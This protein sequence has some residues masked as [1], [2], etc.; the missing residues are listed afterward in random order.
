[1]RILLTGKNG[2]VGAELAGFL[3]R[4]GDVVGFD[5][6]ELNLSNP[7]QIRRAIREVQPNV[8]VNAAAYTAVDR[9]ETDEPQARIINVDAPALMA[10][11]AKRIGAVL[12]HYSTDYVFDGSRDRPYD[13]TDQPNPINVYGQTKFAGEEAIRAVGVPHLILRTAW[14]YGTRGR[15]FLLTILRLATEGEEL[16]IVRDQF[17]APTWSREIAKGTV[18]VLEQL[19]QY[20]QERGSPWGGTYHMTAAGKTTWFGFAEAI[21]ERSLRTSQ[22][23]AWFAAATGGHPLA[24]RRLTPIATEQY[25]TPARRPVYSVL[26]NSRLKEMFGLELADWKVQLGSVFADS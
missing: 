25:P 16:K 1:M 15:N 14:V 24:A 13:E 17:G 23:V 20:R 8:I 18:S 10:E 5:R 11:E 12:V 4:L 9:A 7:D 21:V 19:S 3:P 22:E 6:Y 26:S 2:Q